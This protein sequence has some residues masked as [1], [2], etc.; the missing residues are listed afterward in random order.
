MSAWADC[1]SKQDGKVENYEQAVK[2]MARPK[3]GAEHPQ[4]ENHGNNSPNCM[5]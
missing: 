3:C 4:Q 1:S 5:S 2:E